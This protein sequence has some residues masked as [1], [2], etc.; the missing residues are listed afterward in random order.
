MTPVTLE[1]YA[2]ILARLACRRGATIE[3]VLAELGLAP[4]D[5]ARDEPALRAQLREALARR[6]GIAAMKFA[7]AVGEELEKLALLGAGA[8]PPEPLPAPAVQ[9][10]LALIDPAADSP[11]RWAA[12]AP[13]YVTADPRAAAPAVVSLPAPDPPA[14]A[15]PLRRPPNSLASTVGVSADPPATAAMPFAAPTVSSAY[16]EAPQAACGCVPLRGGLGDGRGRGRDRGA[17]GAAGG[18]RPDPACRT[19]HEARAYCGGPG[20]LPGVRPGARGA[21][22]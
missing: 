14:V 19:A 9:V 1:V 20:A 2:Q 21:G 10:P 7:A 13:S 5:L 3:E 16:A 4:E 18:G 22:C 17:A 11:S 6:K 15:P 12:Q 8:P